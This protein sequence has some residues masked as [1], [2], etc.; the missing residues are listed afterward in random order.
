MGDSPT[1]EQLEMDAGATATE[2]QP[3]DAKIEEERAHILADSL[4]GRRDTLTRKV[5]LL[6]NR[7]PDTRDSD[8]ALQIKYWRM[9]EDWNGVAREEDL[10]RLTRL[11]SIARSRAR[12]QNVLKLFQASSTVRKRR[13]KL[14]EDERERAI[15]EGAPPSA[16][17]VFADESGKTEENLI[18]GGIWFADSN[19][20]L[21]IDHAIAQWR[22]RSG[23]KAEL[24]F[25]EVTDQNEQ[26]YREAFEIV[27]N[28]A[29]SISFKALR[30][31]RK[32]IRNIDSALDQLFYHMLIQG[33][34]HEND[35]LRSVLPKTLQ[36]WKDQEDPSRDKL[37]IA[38]LRDRVEQAGRTLFEGKLRVG[39][40]QPVVSNRV[41][42]MQI[43][44][45]FVSALGRRVNTPG[46]PPKAK[47]RFSSYLLERIGL[48]DGPP[49]GDFALDAILGAPQ[50]TG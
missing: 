36:F 39:D 25:K 1:D 21:A 7:Y 11:T 46:M 24:H 23:F 6:L 19:E 28:N 20:L 2:P 8:V 43:A 10:Y 29:A 32:G 47:D 14:E 49:S 15:D 27:L 18:V 13:G 4:A 16:L 3:A 31:E 45:L 50:A 40:F 38:A 17:T 34:R 26:M 9:F 30:L 12:I 42:M 35:T 33:I 37:R 44:D 48:P 41:E 22:E 5:A